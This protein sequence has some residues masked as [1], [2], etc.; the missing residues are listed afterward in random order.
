MALLPDSQLQWQHVQLAGQAVFCPSQN[1]A[2]SE[3]ASHADIKC[4]VASVGPKDA[5]LQTSYCQLDPPKEKT[6][7]KREQVRAKQA[8]AK[9]KLHAR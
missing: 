8:R 1:P 2:T 3:S 5:T 6:N 4:N 7:E 9:W